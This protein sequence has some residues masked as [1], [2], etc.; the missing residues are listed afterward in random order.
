MQSRRVKI[1]EESYFT[2]HESGFRRLI[3]RGLNFSVI[4]FRKVG[5]PTRPLG[6]P[7]WVATPHSTKWAR[8]P[9]FASAYE[10]AVHEVGVDYR[11]PWRI[12]LLTWAS[13]QTA[14]LVG[15]I[16]ELGTGR[17]FSMTAI[18]H[19]LDFRNI[20]NRSIWC[21]DVFLHH[22]ESG[23]GDATHAMA[24]ASSLDDVTPTLTRWDSVKLVRGDV[25][26]SLN[27]S[28]PEQISLLHV[29]LNDPDIESWA[30]R[31]LWPRVV[32][33]GLMILDDYANFGM[34][35][36]RSIIFELSRE[37]GFEILTLPSG[38][39]LVMK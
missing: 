27:E 31:L 13:A 3:R 4:L 2:F 14:N 16:V 1:M 39:G 25:R 21:F 20:F 32:Q 7:D 6:P 36:S 28:A 38:Q 5:I 19:Y 33:G 22:V 30:I 12:H 29:D 11:I 18:A 15:D 23:L 34:E 26:D 9:S 17:G 35:R 24:Y 8:E 37:L 10:I